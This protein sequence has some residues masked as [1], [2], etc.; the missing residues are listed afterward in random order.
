MW[1]D[2]EGKRKIR[3]RE[4]GVVGEEEEERRS[5]SSIMRYRSSSVVTEIR[6]SRSW[7]GIWYF[8]TKGRFW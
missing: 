6:A 4:E 3:R 1:S 7:C 5:Y 8:M 2:L